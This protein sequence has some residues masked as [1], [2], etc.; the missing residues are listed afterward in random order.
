MKRLLKKTPKDNVVELRRELARA[1]LVITLLSMVC[2]SLIVLSAKSNIELGF[3]TGLLN[4]ASILLGAITVIS[5][6]TALA[7]FSTKK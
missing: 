3:E 5:L 6:T 7:M 4:I 2:I 1:H